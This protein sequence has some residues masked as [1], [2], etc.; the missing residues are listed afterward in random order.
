[1]LLCGC[2]AAPTWSEMIDGEAHGALSGVWG[3]G[4]DDVW[5]VG[6]R[7]LGSAEILH[8]DGMEWTE[9]DAPD[10]ALLAWVFGWSD[11]SAMAVGIDGSVASWDGSSWTALDPGTDQDLWGVWGESEDDVWI[12][13]GTPDATAPTILHY[14]GSTFTPVALDPAQNP[15]DAHQ[16]FKVWGIDGRTWAVG[17]GGLMLELIGDEWTAV[18]AGAQA[19]QDFVSLWGTGADEVVAVGGRA[20]GRVASFDGSA[21]D[22]VSPSGVG[23]LNAVFMDQEDSA[24]V[25]GVSGFVGLFSPA[26]GEL[27]REDSPS[28]LDV[29]A[30]W[31][32][33]ERYWAV[34]GRFS[35]PL[36][37][38]LWVRE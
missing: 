1:M 11:S 17:Q 4:F 23:G 2:P 18:S 6:G 26:T 7:T 36:S 12:V 14:D 37:G 35:E 38:L 29:H 25:G 30:I 10:T 15:R 9:Q 32:D 22:T 19:D 13:G 27:V 3:S 24:V 31:G 34:G 33:G 20:N 28:T 21:W 5:V 8:Y 16:L